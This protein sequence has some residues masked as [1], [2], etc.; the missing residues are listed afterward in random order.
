MLHNST[1]AKLAAGE[2]VH[3]CFIKYP[4]PTLAEMLA[5]A[6]FDFV[7]MDGEHGTLDPRDLADMVRATE[8]RGATPLARVTTNRPEIILRYLDTGLHGVQVPWVNSVSEVEAAVA[9]AKYGPRGIRGLAGGRAT[10]WGVGTSIGDYT[11]IA[12]DQTMVI[13]H[14]ETATAVSQ[15]EAFVEVDGV[16]VVFL[17]PTDL[18]H[19]LGLPGQTAHPDV[20]EA[21]D[22]VAAVVTAS[23]K[24]LGI[25]AGSAAFA[26]EWEGKGAR[27]IATGLDGFVMRG[28]S[29][30]LTGVGR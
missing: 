14:I 20:V 6:G 23:D 16:D 1:K 28:A 21:M 10:D 27:Y 15:V 22:H 24:A 13:V 12:N 18:S 3:G 29:D 30:Y 7:L 25:Y 5:V 17:G 9:A 26:R 19:S 11:A 2:T 4:E 8:L